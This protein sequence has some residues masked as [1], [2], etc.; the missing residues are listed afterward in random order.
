MAEGGTIGLGAARKRT[1]NGHEGGVR[2]VTDSPKN[3]VRDRSTV[4]PRYRRDM[5]PRLAVVHRVALGFACNNACVFCAQGRLRDA[6][7]DDDPAIASAVAAGDTVFFQ[8]GEPTLDADLPGRVARAAA[9]GAALVVVQTNARRLAY[10][11]Y[12]DALAR[13]GGGRLA[14]DV[15]LHGATHD[16]HDFHTSARGSFAQTVAGLRQARRARIPAGIT[17]V[18]T[19]SSYRHLVD[20]ARIA[21]AL[22][23]A[24][25]RFQP[26][27]P[28]GRASIEP[29]RLL[30]PEALARPFVAAAVREAQRLGV[31]GAF[32]FAGLGV[33]EPV[34]KK[35]STTLGGRLGGSRA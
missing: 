13:A 17:V 30:A 16:M 1:S 35:L 24:A 27:A 15:S 28:L 8:G 20:I 31:G 2:T 25:V 22:G 32:P 34:A 11:A 18:Y 4:R 26:V 29:S 14:L 9:S 12:T 21:S 19:R 7:P 23:A 5:Q 3:A 33:A 10:S 6:P